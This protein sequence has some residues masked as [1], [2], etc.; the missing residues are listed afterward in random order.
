MENTLEKKRRRKGLIGPVV[1][2]II[3]IELL[4]ART[5]VI[6]PDILYQ[7]W[8]LHLIFVGGWLLVSRINRNR[9]CA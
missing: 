8:P 7:W 9:D 2:L 4:L 6:P 3:G 5:G 1:L